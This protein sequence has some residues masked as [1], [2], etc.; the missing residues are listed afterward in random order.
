VKILLAD[1]HQIFRE[2]L[3]ALLEREGCEIVAEAADGR[4]AARLARRLAPDIA[5]LDL[6]MPLLNGV[7]A[8]RDI[9][10]H[11]P[12]TRTLLLTMFEEAAYVLAALKAG[13]R[14]YVLKAQAAADLMRAI[15]EVLRGAIY[16][17]PGI[18]RIVVDAY[19]NKGTAVDEPLSHRERHVLQL[20]AEGH[21][22]KEIALEL[23]V[24]F[25]TVESHR[26]RIMRKLDIHNT[27]GLVRY[28]IR[29]G[30]VRA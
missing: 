29:R 1:D 9:Q 11:A 16:L 28:A 6:G 26:T 2:S 13:V 10:R 8:A 15:D 12:R 20:V 19:L 22:T 25:K 27:A 5:V 7:D 23:G 3:K 30:L 18:S 14:G 17:S 4:Q 21:S 24:G